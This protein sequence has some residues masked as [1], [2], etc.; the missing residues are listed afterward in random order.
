VGGLLAGV[1]GGHLA[2]TAGYGTLFASLVL[3]AL[4][5]TTVGMVALYR[6]RRRCD[7][8]PHDDAARTAPEQGSG[9]TRV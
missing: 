1:V 2:D 8:E 6:A 9:R 3:V 5:G 4:A 7:A